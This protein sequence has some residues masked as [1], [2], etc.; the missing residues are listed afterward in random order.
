MLVSYDAR[1]IKDLVQ[2][3]LAKTSKHQI[4]YI[5]E[6]VCICCVCR[7]LV[8]ATAIFSLRSAGALLHYLVRRRVGQEMLQ[9]LLD[10]WDVGVFQWKLSRELSHLIDAVAIQWVQ[11][12][13]HILIAKS[14]VCI[15]LKVTLSTALLELHHQ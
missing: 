10:C 7:I 8:T 1:E 2:K 4:M 15:S 6:K 14:H 11:V 9:D 13:S 12:Y 3:L 5:S